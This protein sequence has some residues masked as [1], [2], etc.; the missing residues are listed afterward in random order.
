MTTNSCFRGVLTCFASQ[1]SPILLNHTGNGPLNTG[2]A[3]LIAV[4]T[5]VLFVVMQK[6]SYWRNDEWRW[7]HFWRREQWSRHREAVAA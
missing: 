5:V 7:P 2:W 4:S 6:G 3:V 1:V